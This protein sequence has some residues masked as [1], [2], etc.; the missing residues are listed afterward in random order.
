MQ[1]DSNDCSILKECATLVKSETVSVRASK[2]HQQIRFTAFNDV[3]NIL[4]YHQISAKVE[5]DA[6]FAISTERLIALLCRKDTKI[7]LG[8]DG[9]ALSY[10]YRGSK[11]IVEVYGFTAHE[12]PQIK[13]D[14]VLTSALKK[15]ASYLSLKSS[16]IEGVSNFIFIEEGDDTYLAAADAGAYHAVLV[17]QSGT[18]TEPSSLTLPQEH[19]Q[20]ALR[21]L[22]EDIQICSVGEHLFCFTRD[23]NENVSI[24]RFRNM[25]ETDIKIE[26]IKKAAKSSNAIEFTIDSSTFDDVLSN[27]KL[28]EEEGRGGSIKI[29]VEPELVTMTCQTRHG[30]NSLDVAVKTG[31]SLSFSVSSKILADILRFKGPVHVAVKESMNIM[32]LTQKEKLTEVVFMCSIEKHDKS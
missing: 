11:G 28:V 19:V 31:G 17:K 9:K 26:I 29:D 32:T 25:V 27:Q 22:K 15:S 30:N 5:E 8:Y 18:A 2:K 12:N 4:L 20:N 6:R 21:A 7:T 3:T 24:I 13:K 16:L 1:I 10:K 14:R 23:D